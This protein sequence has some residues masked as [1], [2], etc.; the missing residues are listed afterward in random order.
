MSQQ[1]PLSL[2]LSQHHSFDTFECAGNEELCSQLKKYISQKHSLPLVYVWSGA[3]RGK[4]H[5]LNAC[6]HLAHNKQLTATLIPLSSNKAYTPDI[7]LGLEDIDLVCID[8]INAICGQAD[9]ERALFNL[10]NAIQ[11]RHGRLIVSA[12]N[13]AESS[14]IQLADLR[15]RLGWGLTLHINQSNDTNRRAI[16]QNMA[17]QKGLK[18]PVD[19]AEYLLKRSH[20][21]VASMVRLIESLDHASLSAKRPLTIPFVR[22]V[23]DNDQNA[24]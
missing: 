18:M 21:D 19:V 12:T 13:K 23:I 3:T 16:L 15:S 9:W 1:L 4:T 7:L 6:C 10:F 20:R 17:S 8:D 11:E 14:N 2:S 22:Q 24:L 5:L